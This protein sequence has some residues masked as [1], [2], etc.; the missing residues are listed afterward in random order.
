M[1]DLLLLAKTSSEET[2]APKNAAP[3][4]AFLHIT[5]T[6]FKFINTNSAKFTEHVLTG[7]VGFIYTELDTTILGKYAL[8]NAVKRLPCCNLPFKFSSIKLTDDAKLA[9]EYY[10]KNFS[11]DE[12]VRQFYQGWF[13]EAKDGKTTF[14]DLT[15]IYLIYDEVLI[16]Q[17][18]ESTKRFAIK[19]ACNTLKTR[20]AD[21]NCIIQKLP[22]VARDSHAFHDVMSSKN[23]NKTM[24]CIY[25]LC[26]NDAVQDER[27]LKTFHLKWQGAISIFKEVFVKKDIVGEP[28]VEL[29]A[30][31][32]KTSGKQVTSKTKEQ[33]DKDGNAF[34]NK[35]ITPIPLSYS[36]TA[37]KEL[38]FESIKADINHVKLHCRNIWNESIE[39]LNNFKALAERGQVR[40]ELLGPANKIP[41]DMSQDENICASFRHYGFRYKGSNYPDWITGKNKDK[42]LLTLLAMPT[43]TTMSA[44]CYLLIEMHPQITPSWLED[45]DLYNNKG[46]RHGYREVSGV[47][48]ALSKKERKGKELAQQE[49]VLNAESKKLIEEYLELTEQLRTQL[50]QES[51]DSFRKMLISADSIGSKA[52]TYSSNK[53]NTTALSRKLAEPSE[54]KTDT[55]AI[56]ISKHVTHARMRSAVGVRVYLETGSVHAMSEA[57]GHEKYIPVLINHYLPK[58][59]WD[60]FTNRWIRQFQNAIVYEAMKDSRYLHKAIDIH[61]DELN[62]FLENH[63]LGE[64][65]EHIRTGK[66]KAMDIAND[67]VC[68]FEGAVFLVSTSLLQI[69]MALVTTV[70]NASDDTE[71]TQFAKNWYEAA[72][73]VLS[74]ISVA[75]ENRKGNSPGNAE[76]ISNDIADMYRVATNKPLNPELIEEAILWQSA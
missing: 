64:L 51:N 29:L 37:A 42:N 22:I 62:S 24:S 61:P 56:S 17:I 35:L 28:R 46:D 20:L 23:I 3:L 10:K 2:R 63:G 70:D 68:Q 41:V 69:F 5:S 14:L 57:L 48:I 55:H 49:V 53:P 26:L 54:H 4:N 76:M 60:Y 7:F 32:F 31:E 8:A 13:V 38:I 58:P 50:Q 71:I 25:S 74:H 16:S 73:F 36:D 6:K 19:E 15:S 75:L 44:F 52:R 12:Q 66:K 9:V 33:K 45:W 72:K 30:P 34:N 43:A 47:W 59:L 11:V 18:H 21:F 65:P 67:N 40:P 39:N 1:Y 27:C